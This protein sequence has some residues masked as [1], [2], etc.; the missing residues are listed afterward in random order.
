MMATSS[1]DTLLEVR[2]LSKAFGGVRATNDINLSLRSG[3][4]RCVIGP[5]GAGKS[6]LFKLLMGMIMPDS[7]PSSSRAR[8]LP[9]HNRTDVLVSES[10]S[11]F[12][13]WEYI[14]T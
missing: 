3:E 10:A 13:I 1:P 8:T 4:L 9:A 11:S 12:R 14:L 5:N 2:G 7:G 6:T